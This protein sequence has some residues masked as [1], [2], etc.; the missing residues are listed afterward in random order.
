M[1]KKPFASILLATLCMASQ[2]QSKDP[3]AKSSYLGVQANQLLRQ[4]FNFGSSSSTVT[5]PYLLNYSRNSDSTGLGFNV[6]VGYSFDQFKNGDAVFERTTK[7]NDLFLRAGFDRKYWLGRKWM[8]GWGIDVVLDNQKNNTTTKTDSDFNKSTITT[9]SKLNALGFG[10]RL[11]L[12]YRITDRIL[13]GT[14]CTYYF[15]ALKDSEEIESKISTREVDPF[16]GQVIF[17]TR[18]EKE[19]SDD[20][21]KK[22]QFNVPA[23]LFLTLKF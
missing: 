4:L 16:T 13:I 15:K 9:T 3:K 21:L 12:H 19:E 20:K 14:E 7:L 22:L 5:T 17:I 8:A 6:G 18:T 23:I 11:T 2:A 10:P 1:I